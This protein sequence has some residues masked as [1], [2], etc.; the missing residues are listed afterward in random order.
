[1]PLPHFLASFFPVPSL[2]Y[3]QKEKE[4]ETQKSEGKRSW[5]P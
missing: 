2:P 5:G 4:K 3:L 1:M